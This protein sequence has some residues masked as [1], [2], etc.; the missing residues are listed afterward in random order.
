MKPKKLY[1]TTLVIWTEYD[2]DMVASLEDL[3]REATS[4]EGYCE[5]SECYLITDPDAMPDTE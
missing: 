5:S 4:G 2:T 3:A 1:K